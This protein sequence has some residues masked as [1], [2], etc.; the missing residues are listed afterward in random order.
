MLSNECN[1]GRQ[2]ASL[3]DDQGR[4]WFPTQDGISILDPSLDE[5]NPLP[6]TVVIEEVL[7]EREPV[8]ARSGLT[9]DAGKRDLEINYTGIS[10][11]KSDQV[12][13]Q[14]KLDGHD[15]DWI[16]AGTRRV[17]NYSYLPPG[18]YRFLVKAANSDGVWT[19]QP[20][21]LNVR[22]KPFFYS[23]WLFWAAAA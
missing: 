5:P 2:P 21:L 19:T 9:V 4:F 16:D 11:I 8:D 10:L 6:P 20:A 13:F 12:K 17:A 14:Y 18:D 1:G 23:T 3:R 7:V 22:L 15:K